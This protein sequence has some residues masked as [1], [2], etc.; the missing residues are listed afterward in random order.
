MSANYAKVYAMKT[1]KSVME[2]RLLWLAHK[3]KSACGSIAIV[4]VGFQNKT[5]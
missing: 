3:N 2:A 5:K 4:P 1:G